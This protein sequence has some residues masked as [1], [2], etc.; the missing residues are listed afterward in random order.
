[1]IA[2]A[3]R[4]GSLNDDSAERFEGSELAELNR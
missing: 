4:V 1:M 2:A 3:P